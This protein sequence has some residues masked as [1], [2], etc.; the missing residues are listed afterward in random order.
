MILTADLMR[1]FRVHN[2]KAELHWFPLPNFT[3][4]IR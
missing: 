1:A 4:Y 3:L 2:L